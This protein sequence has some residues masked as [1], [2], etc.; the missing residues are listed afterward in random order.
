MPS[1]PRR[2]T[3]AELENLAFTPEEEMRLTPLDLA[4]IKGI[5]FELLNSEHLT[6]E[7]DK[8]RW[9]GLRK[10]YLLFWEGL[11]G[12]VNDREKFFDSISPSA[13]DWE[14]GS[15]SDPASDTGDTEEEVDPLSKLVSEI[16]SRLRGTLAS[17]KTLTPKK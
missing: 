11:E 5:Q 12:A 13:S 14:T 10:E 4:R 16:L 15:E 17:M 3:V 7:D 1:T 9:R 6:K 8:P 2:K